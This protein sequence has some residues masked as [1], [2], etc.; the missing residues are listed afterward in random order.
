MK[1]GAKNSSETLEKALAKLLAHGVLLNR[2]LD[3][4]DEN[5]GISYWTFHR[6]SG[7]WILILHS[8]SSVSAL[9]QSQGEGFRG[10]G[11]RGR[12]TAL[13]ERKIN[14]HNLSISCIPFSISHLIRYC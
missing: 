5:R 7:F 3:S 9:R 14:T 10:R 8:N 4:F 2:E 12:C 11:R 13:G 6:S 1:I